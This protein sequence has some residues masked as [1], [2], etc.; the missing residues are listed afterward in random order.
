[1][2]IFASDDGEDWE[3][4]MEPQNVKGPQANMLEKMSLEDALNTEYRF[5]KFEFGDFITSAIG[6]TE[7]RFT[8]SRF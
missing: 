6:V 7:V 8:G 3:Q 2:T 1:M 5:W 4:V